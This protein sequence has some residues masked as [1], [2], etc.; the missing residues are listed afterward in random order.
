MAHTSILE[1]PEP[2]QPAPRWGAAGRWGAAMAKHRK[3]VLGV[4]LL[5]VVICGAAYPALHGRLGTPDYSVPGSESVEVDRLV[6][7]HFSQFGTE[8][9]VIVFHSTRETVDAPDYRAAVDRALDVAKQTKG[10][11]GAVG[12]FQGNAAQISAD[13]RTAFAVV[14]V[15]GDI[16]ARVQVVRELREALAV[17]STDD[18]KV[19][20]SGYAP[21]QAD[22]MDIETA[23][24]QRAEAVGLPVATVLLVLALGAM[25]AA[26][27]PITVT[28]AGIAVAI[29]ILFGLTSFLAFD[30]MVLS[31]AT[32][33]ATGTAIDYAMFIVSRFNEELT[34]RGVRNRKDRTAIAEAVGTAMDTTGRTVLAS[35]LIVMIS[36]CSLAVVGLPMLNGIAI[37]VIAAVVSTMGAAFTLL[38]ALLATLGPAVNRGAVPERMRPA[39]VRTTT[40][41]SGWARWAH[42]VMARPVLFGAVGV[43]L[44]LLAA[45]PLTGLRYG[46]DM[47]LNSLGDR[48]SGQAIALVEQNFTPGLLGPIEVVATGA[49]AAP[50]SGNAR[51]EADRFLAELSRDPRIAAVLPQY[52]DGRMFAAVIPKTTFGSTAATDLVSDIRSRASGLGDAE[53]RVGGTSALFVDVSHRIVSRFPV[54]IALVLAVSLIFLVVAFRSIVL[55]LKAIL[56]NLLATGAALGITIAV[57]Q[58]GIGEGLLGFQSTGFLQIYLP[59]LVFAVLFGLSMDYEVFL[60]RRMKE[61]WDA[62]H[63]NAPAVADG[64]QRT[65]RPI[66]AAAAIMVAVFASF[67]TADVLE[68]KQVGFAL[69]VAIAID[70]ILVR[71][72]LVPAFMRLFGRWNWW[73]PTFGSRSAP[74]TI[75]K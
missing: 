1:R 14:G 50:L 7:E 39:E 68:L 24:M 26:L 58:T 67:V 8:Q 29:G 33:I 6:A 71:L 60:I 11:A 53:I 62:N 23:D 40:A 64:L 31:I 66:T 16:S 19:M 42:T 18:I 61:H 4:W 32:M 48:P 44:L 41:S 57:F 59:M 47:G 72:I 2:T 28:A 30:S 63:D 15:D 70:A 17:G 73:L 38:P 25:V 21:I 51:D 55:A 74:A 10:V 35:G 34:R 54:L 13:R 36:L 45:T 12:P 37:G 75:G 5:L 65:A 52:A 43:A 9:D 3:V 56:L 46:V 69:A 22:L 27:L 49:E 20:L